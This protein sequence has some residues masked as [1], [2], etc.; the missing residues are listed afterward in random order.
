MI[1]AHVAEELTERPW[2]QVRSHTEHQSTQ[3]G[4]HQQQPL[5][6]AQLSRIRRV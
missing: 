5:T 2:R 4:H 3:Q 1:V 6:A